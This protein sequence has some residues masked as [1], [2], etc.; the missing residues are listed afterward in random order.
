MGTIMTKIETAARALYADA[1][2]LD[3][4]AIE[5][6]KTRTAEGSARCRDLM[7]LATAKRKEAAA[8]WDV[9][10]PPYRAV[11]PADFAT[12]YRRRYGALK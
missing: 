10:H 2:A 5:A 12:W 8:A 9:A 3:A 7:A 11:G 6:D 4:Q 1:D